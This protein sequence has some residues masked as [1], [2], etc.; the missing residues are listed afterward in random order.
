MSLDFDDLVENLLN[1]QKMNMLDSQKCSTTARNIYNYLTQSLD[2]KGNNNLVSLEPNLNTFMDKIKENIDK[3]YIYYIHFDHITNET[4]HYF[5]ICNLHDKIVI[6]QSAVFEFSIYDWIFPEQAKA[7]NLLVLQE[8]IKDLEKSDDR[9]DKYY[10]EEYKR[11][12]KKQDTILDN[13]I[14]ND[15][16]CGK[17]KTV[18]ELN[19]FILCL[20]GLEGAWTLENAKEMCELYSRVFSCVLDEDRIKSQIKLGIK[21]GAFKYIYGEISAI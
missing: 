19:E 18:D 14:N 3:N 1:K 2:I 17:Y 9:L 21:P 16:S 12:N 7:A 6:L 8:K 11:T 5:I 13:I 10:A 15:Y 4:S 20:I